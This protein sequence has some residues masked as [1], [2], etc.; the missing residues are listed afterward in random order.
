MFKS[1]ESLA[2]NETS[3]A[4]SNETKPI[5]SPHTDEVHM[6]PAK[7]FRRSEV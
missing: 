5:T 4:Q 2:S 3:N 6:P 7:H 1:D